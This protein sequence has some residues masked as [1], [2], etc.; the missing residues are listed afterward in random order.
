MASQ[1]TVMQ[2]AL[3]SGLVGPSASAALAPPT[4]VA[5]AAATPNRSSVSPRLGRFGEHAA[6]AE[7]ETQDGANPRETTQ[8]R[9]G[10]QTR[11]GGVAIRGQRPELPPGP[12]GATADSLPRRHLA[13]RADDVSPLTRGVLEFDHFGSGEPGSCDGDAVPVEFVLRAGALHS[14]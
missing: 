1:G 9:P 8:A 6:V 12:A 2:S 10:G 13:P 14:Q 5:T 3:T 7:S 11:P 4:D